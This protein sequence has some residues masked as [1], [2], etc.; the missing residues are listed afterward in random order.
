MQKHLRRRAIVL[1]MSFKRTDA[2]VIGAAVSPKQCSVAWRPLFTCFLRNRSMWINK[3]PIYSKGWCLFVHIV[4]GCNALSRLAHKYR[5]ILSGTH[6][7]ILLEFYWKD[8][9]ACMRMYNA[10]ALMFVVGI[11]IDWYARVWSLCLI[12]HAYDKQHRA[13]GRQCCCYDCCRLYEMTNIVVLLFRVLL[14]VLDRNS[15]VSISIQKI[16]IHLWDGGTIATFACVCIHASVIARKNVYMGKYFATRL[17]V[18]C[19]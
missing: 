4:F 15:R 8:N 1:I 6:E 5:I 13:I 14:F 3:E 17:L 9:I 7:S 11:I 10:N 19:H 2:I 18:Y 12:N 16:N